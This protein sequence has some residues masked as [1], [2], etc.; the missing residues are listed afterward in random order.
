MLRGAIKDFLLIKRASYNAANGA[1]KADEPIIETTWIPESNHS[2]I[3]E[4]RWGERNDVA[5]PIPNSNRHGDGISLE[6]HVSQHKPY[7]AY[8]PWRGLRG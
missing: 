6:E 2:E 4:A 5:L 3:L 7:V 1:G 8:R